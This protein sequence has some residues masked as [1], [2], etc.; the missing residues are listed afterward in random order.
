MGCPQADLSECH[1]V[2]APLCKYYPDRR[3]RQLLKERRDGK[4]LLHFT[5]KRFADTLGSVRIEEYLG[6]QR[7]K[8]KHICFR[9]LAH[10]NAVTHGATVLT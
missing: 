5:R 1:Q 2:A 9:S 7:M 6:G 3:S 8:T 10:K 4:M